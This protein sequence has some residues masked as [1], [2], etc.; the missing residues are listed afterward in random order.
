MDGSTSGSRTGA[1]TAAG[2]TRRTVDPTV[3][4][5]PKRRFLGWGIVAGVVGYATVALLFG[6]FNLFAGRSFFFTAALLGQMVLGPVVPPDELVVSA[7]PVLIYNALH[8]VA[9]VVIGTVA[10]ALLTLAE[11]MPKAGHLVF[12]LFLV[13]FLFSVA[14]ILLFAAPVAEAMPWGSVFA[15]NAAAGLTMGIVLVRTVAEEEHRR[16]ELAE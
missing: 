15:A 4:V 1:D 8:F 7:L 13:G 5:D 16:H 9:F 10:A 11:R 3:A 14:L 12:F 2:P 6:I